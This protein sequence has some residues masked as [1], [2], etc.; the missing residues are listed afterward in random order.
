MGSEL[1]FRWWRGEWRG[2][3]ASREKM[4]DA[5]WST[6]SSRTC[7]KCEGGRGRVPL[8][9]K[10]EQDREREGEEGG[11]ADRGRNKESTPAQT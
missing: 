4:D 9:T 3:V 6:R 11:R 7:T 2:E 10:G 1:L 5:G 8:G